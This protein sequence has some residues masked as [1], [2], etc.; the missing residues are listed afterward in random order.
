MTIDNANKTNHKSLLA[1]KEEFTERHG[2]LYGHSGYEVEIANIRVTGFIDPK[3]I[4]PK[5]IFSSRENNQIVP[6]ISQ[7]SEAIFD[8]KSQRI[9]IYLRTELNS[10][11]QIIGPALVTQLDTTTLVTPDWIGQVDLEG[12]LILSRKKS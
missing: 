3:F 5:P 8:G 7:Y 11:D 2:H 12:N 9:P 4:P 1:A 6:A 10:D